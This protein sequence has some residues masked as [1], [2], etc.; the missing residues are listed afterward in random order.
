M[1]LSFAAHHDEDLIPP[2]GYRHRRESQP[3]S[4]RRGAQRIG[5]TIAKVRRRR[6]GA[7]AAH[8]YGTCGS[9]IVAAAIRCDWA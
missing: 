1:P 9:N 7:C 8:L 2:V 3:T 5:V 4:E 6:L